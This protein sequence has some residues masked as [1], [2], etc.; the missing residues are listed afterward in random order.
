LEAIF[1]LL[2]S[3]HLYIPSSFHPSVPTN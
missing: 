2:V 3:D 1:R